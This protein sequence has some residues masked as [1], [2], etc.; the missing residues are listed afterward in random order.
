MDSLNWVAIFGVTLMGFILGPLWYG[1]LL[2]GNVWMRIHRH[3]KKS[4]AEQKKEME[5]MWK[6]MVSEFIATLLIMTGLAWIIKA[7]AMNTEGALHV[8][9]WVW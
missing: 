6:L 8:A 2:F 1:P 5:G 7:T 3:D 9:L 4:P